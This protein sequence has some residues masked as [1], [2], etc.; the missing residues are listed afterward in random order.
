MVHLT[1]RFR[2]G[3]QKADGDCAVQE[4]KEVEGQGRDCAE[5]K[6]RSDRAAGVG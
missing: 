6:C 4:L 5:T 3:L 1:T 2:D